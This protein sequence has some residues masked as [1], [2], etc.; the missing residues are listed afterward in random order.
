SVTSTNPACNS[1]ISTQPTDF[2]VN[3][4]DSINP[5]TLQASDFTVN[6]TP[7]NTVTYTPGTTT[8]TFHFNSSPVATQGVQTMHIPAGA[9]NRASDNQPNLDF[10]CTFRYDVLL[11][12]VVSTVPSVGGSFSP[13]APSNYQYDVNFNEAVDPASVQTTDLMVSGNSGPSVTAVSVINGNMNAQFV[14]TDNNWGNSCPLPW[15]T[16]NYT[17]FPYWDD[18]RTDVNLGCLGFPG[19]TCG[20]FTSITGSAPNRIFNIEWRTVYFSDDSQA[21]NY[22]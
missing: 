3:V 13:P 18:Q 1:V 15:T 21:A 5:A 17:V 9:F 7:A 14:T 10:T 8:M 19:G 22:E 12:Q 20:I 16:H 6:G 4:T 11:L 2:I